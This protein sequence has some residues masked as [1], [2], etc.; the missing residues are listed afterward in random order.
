MS[1]RALST[2]HA[3]ISSKRSNSGTAVIS[4]DFSFTLICPRTRRFRD[5]QAL[6]RW[7]G[8][9]PD[10][11]LWERRTVLKLQKVSVSRKSGERQP[12]GAQFRCS[13][14]V[15]DARIVAQ[16]EKKAKAFEIPFGIY[17]SLRDGTQS[18]RI[19]ESAG[20]SAI[21]LRF[22]NRHRAGGELPI[23]NSPFIHPNG[24]K[25]SRLKSLTAIVPE[26]E[27]ST[28]NVTQANHIGNRFLP[29]PCS[30]R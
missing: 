9:I 19:S 25:I 2:I 13:P 16:R 11:L 28:P 1:F 23:R 17:F 15:C 21:L 12:R 8:P 14:G 5:A 18:V 30:L 24:P 22:R 26:G 7:R 4:F 20:G 3:L 29:S 10:L 6:T 27:G